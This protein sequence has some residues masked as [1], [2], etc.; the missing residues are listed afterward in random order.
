MKPLF[1]ESTPTEDALV[2]FMRRDRWRSEPNPDDPTI[3][4]CLV[5]TGCTNEDGYGVVT[6]QMTNGLRRTYYTHRLRFGVEVGEIPEGRELAHACHNRACGNV[7][8]LVP[9][10][11]AENVQTLS[12]LFSSTYQPGSTPAS[13]KPKRVKA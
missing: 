1:G 2:G 4:P 11:H 5:W 8:H 13:R 7:D 9:K 12:T 3:G 10:T 6:V